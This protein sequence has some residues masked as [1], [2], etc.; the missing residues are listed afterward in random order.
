MA[1]FTENP[2]EIDEEDSDSL[3]ISVADRPLRKEQNPIFANLGRGTNLGYG[4]KKQ[5]SVA[6]DRLWTEEQKLIFAKQGK[7]V[8]N[9]NTQ[10]AGKLVHN[11]S[12]V[13]I[14]RINPLELIRCCGSQDS[15]FLI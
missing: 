4:S 12:L 1:K 2:P 13:F 8:D 11:Y 10:S 15:V 5:I 3:Q 6:D 9:Q 7:G 14:F